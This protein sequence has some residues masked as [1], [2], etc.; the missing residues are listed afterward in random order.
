MAGR[1]LALG[2]LAAGLFL[3]SCDDPEPLRIGFIGDLSGPGFDIGRSARNTLQMLVAERNSE[4]GIGGRQI[5]VL[6]LDDAGD[7]ETAKAAALELAAANVDAI[8][9]P[10]ISAMAEAVVPIINEHRIVTLSPTVASREF[11]GIDD[12]FFRSSG[13]LLDTTKDFA[14]HQAAKGR[15]RIAVAANEGNPFFARSWLSAFESALIESGGEISLV[16]SFRSDET[17]GYSGVVSELHASRSDAVL[18]IANSVD[19]ARLVQQYRKID[20]DTPMIG[21]HWGTTRSLIDHGGRAVQGFE[22]I[23]S[24]D[25]EG[26]SERFIALREQYGRHFG[27]QMDFTVAGM[28]DAVAVLF[29][30]LERRTNFSSLKEAFLNLGAVKG[31]QYDLEFDSFG[32]ATPKGYFFV[33]RGNEFVRE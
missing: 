16:R 32:D 33:V 2:V 12:Y 5:E 26:T 10:F 29:A 27:R 14:R 9:G 18:V 15:K 6:F 17:Q 7:P 4:G 25:L 20:A 13:N 21:S 8:V 3:A 31:I 30:A 24:Y 1:K 23:Q 28:F 11:S 19:T 22:A